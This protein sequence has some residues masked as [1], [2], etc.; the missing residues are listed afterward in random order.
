MYIVIITERD[1]FFYQRAFERSAT[2]NPLKKILHV[3]FLLYTYSLYK[4]LFQQNDDGSAPVSP[5]ID[6]GEF[7][8]QLLEEEHEMEGVVVAHEPDE[9]LLRQDVL[10]N[11][12]VA[13]QLI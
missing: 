4:Q 2:F 8:R 12:K 11:N 5:T 9:Y 10:P 7:F 13:R 6:D 3:L 1:F